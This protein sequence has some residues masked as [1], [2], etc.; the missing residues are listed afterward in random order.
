M[1]GHSRSN[2][3]GRK[4]ADGSRQTKAGGRERSGMGHRP[5]PAPKQRPKAFLHP[6]KLPQAKRRQ[7][8]NLPYVQVLRLGIIEDP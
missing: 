4:Q 2:G 1:A 3:A 5:P 6:A 7:E 8:P